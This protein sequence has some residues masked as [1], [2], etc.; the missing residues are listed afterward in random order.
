MTAKEQGNNRAYQKRQKGS[1]ISKESIRISPRKKQASSQFRSLNM[2]TSAAASSRRKRPHN[3]ISASKKGKNGSTNNRSKKKRSGEDPAGMAEAAT[4]GRPT[5]SAETPQSTQQS[6]LQ[7]A[8]AYLS[9][10]STNPPPPPLQSKRPSIQTSKLVPELS[11][12]PP[13]FGGRGDG[14]NVVARSLHEPKERTTHGTTL[15]GTKKQP[16]SN[17]NSGSNIS[18]KAARRKGRLSSGPSTAKTA[19]LLIFLLC[20]SLLC[21]VGITSLWFHQSASLQLEITKL[22]QEINDYQMRLDAYEQSLHGKGAVAADGNNGDVDQTNNV[23]YWKSL[24]QQE[25]SRIDGIRKDCDE[26]MRRLEETCSL[27][28]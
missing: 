9:S 4:E 23:E 7:R 18:K 6:F 13:P 15:D 8:A 27:S 16:M 11:I 5:T 14:G 28:K 10:P 3:A 22:Q 21:L 17:G 1:I 25:E 2:V 19:F 24:L 12:P 20:L 26:G